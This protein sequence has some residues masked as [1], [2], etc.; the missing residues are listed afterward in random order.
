MSAIDEFAEVGTA[1]V[2]LD[3]ATGE[4]PD[5]NGEDLDELDEVEEGKMTWVEALH[6][7]YKK[8]EKDLKKATPRRAERAD[9]TAL[10]RKI[11]RA[12]R[13]WWG[14]RSASTSD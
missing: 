6:D 14:P 10:T 13:R 2:G 5:L 7:F 12:R 1:G 3:G 8:F 11:L 4:E 9:R